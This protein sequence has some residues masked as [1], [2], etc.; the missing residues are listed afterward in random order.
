V[1]RR[2]LDQVDSAR[3]VHVHYHPS[4]RAAERPCS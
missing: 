2:L 4:V 3:R 1:E